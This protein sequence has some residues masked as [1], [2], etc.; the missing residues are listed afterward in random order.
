MMLPSKVNY[1]LMSEKASREELKGGG[2]HHLEKAKLMQKSDGNPKMDKRLFC[3]TA[4]HYD[5]HDFPCATVIAVMVSTTYK[6]IS[7]RIDIYY[8]FF[9]VLFL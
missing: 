6:S 8:I 3:L 5:H 4:F 1:G 7:I 2:S 9:A